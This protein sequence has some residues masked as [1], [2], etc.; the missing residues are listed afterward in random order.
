MDFNGRKISEQEQTIEFDLAQ[1]WGLPGD[2][3]NYGQFTMVRTFLWAR[4]L[5]AN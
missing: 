2:K 3:L 4:G 1:V 5:A